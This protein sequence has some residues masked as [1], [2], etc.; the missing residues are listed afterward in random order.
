MGNRARADTG[1]ILPANQVMLIL[2]V[3]VPWTEPVMR[4]L[5]QQG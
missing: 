4:S 2:C 3:S 5:S 1:L